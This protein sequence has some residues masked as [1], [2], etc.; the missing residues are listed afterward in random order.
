MFVAVFSLALLP[1]YTSSSLDDVLYRI[2]QLQ[3]SIEVKTTDHMDSQQKEIKELAESVRLA[4]KRVDN[5][6]NNLSGADARISILSGELNSTRTSLTAEL[7]KVK[8]N[9]AGVEKDMTQ[10]N[11]QLAHANKNISDV[12]DKV[13]SLAM[14]LNITDSKLEIAQQEITNT[15]TRVSQLS[16]TIDNMP[17]IMKS[18]QHKVQKTKTQVDSLSNGLDHVIAKVDTLDRKVSETVKLDSGG[19]ISPSILPGSYSSYTLED[20]QW[21]TLHMS[22]AAACTGSD[23]LKGSAKMLVPATPGESCVWTCNNTDPNWTCGS[24]VTLGGNIKHISYKSLAGYYHRS[25][26]YE[27]ATS[28]KSESFWEKEEIL[29]SKGETS[30]TS[31]SYCC[32]SN[33]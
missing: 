18:L 12:E 30:L 23:A 2:S 16:G 33:Y 7:R 32:C 27:K 29:K 5:L 13:E 28:E 17:G 10:V 26:C 8:A 21:Q 19:L 9:F 15:T 4:L 6:E 11:E 20:V 22:A 1:V 3:K 25:S 31:L 14:I 24:T